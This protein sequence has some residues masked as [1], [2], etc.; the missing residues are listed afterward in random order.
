MGRQLHDPADP[1]L[2]GLA[3]YLREQ[4]CYFDGRA[5]HQ[6]RVLG[7]P[8]VRESERRSLENQLQHSEKLLA[9]WR[10]W[11]DGLQELRAGGKAAA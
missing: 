2:D 1:S 3:A 5:G 9:V 10:S 6:R 7:H 11:L 8:G 4:V